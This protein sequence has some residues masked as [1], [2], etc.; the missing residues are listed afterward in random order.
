M[1]RNAEAIATEMDELSKQIDE[2]NY[3][4][5]AGRQEKMRVLS[6]RRD[7]LNIEHTAELAKQMYVT[8]PVYGWICF[9]CGVRCFSVAEAKEHFGELPTAKPVCTKGQTQKFRE[10]AQKIMLEALSTLADPINPFSPPKDANGFTAADRQIM[11]D[12]PT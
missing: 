4:F 8:M 6:A 9:H 10:A 11:R 3:T 1:E 5:V 12:D 7:A 2:T